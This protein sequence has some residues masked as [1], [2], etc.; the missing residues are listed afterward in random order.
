MLVLFQRHLRY[1]ETLTATSLIRARPLSHFAVQ[2]ALRTPDMK[3]GFLWLLKQKH[4]SSAAPG[5][6]PLKHVRQQV[7]S[8]TW[9]SRWN[10]SSI[11]NPFF[12]GACLDFFFNFVF[13]NHWPQTNQWINY[14]FSYV[15]C[16]LSE[17]M[18]SE[19]GLAVFCALSVQQIPLSEI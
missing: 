12:W 19:L 8:C 14:I 7:S 11:W 4:S 2:R 9:K 18:S 13:L 3:H 1:V 10:T 16:L 17:E 5:A 6:S 15:N